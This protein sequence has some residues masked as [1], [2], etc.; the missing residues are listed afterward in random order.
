[1]LC[2]AAELGLSEERSG[3]M[4]LAGEAPPGT[5]LGAWLGLDD[6]IIEVDLTPDRADCLSVR[7]L[8]RDLSAK[9]DLPLADHPA[10][11]LEPEVTTR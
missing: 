11:P 7:G 4:E 3:I 6:A 2:S 1:M 5:E 8:A 9:N 10:P